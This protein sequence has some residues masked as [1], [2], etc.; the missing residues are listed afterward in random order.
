MRTQIRDHLVGHCLPGI[1]FHEGALRIYVRKTMGKAFTSLQG[2][3]FSAQIPLFGVENGA[4]RWTLLGAKRISLTLPRK[5]ARNR[6]TTHLLIY[7]W[8]SP[9]PTGGSF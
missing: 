6:G 2:L 1:Q 9:L 7:K 4:A 3:Q 8:M 5:I